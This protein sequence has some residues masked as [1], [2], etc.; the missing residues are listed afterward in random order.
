MFMTRMPKS[1]KKKSG[2]TQIPPGCYTATVTDVVWSP[3]YRQG[4]AVDV[5]YLISVDDDDPSVTES[6]W[7]RFLLKSSSERT[8][9]F[10]ELLDEIGA[11]NYSDFIGTKLSVEFERASDSRG[12]YHS[13]IVAHSLME[14]GGQDDIDCKESSSLALGQAW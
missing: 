1:S 8:K 3:G 11:E 6:Y 12:Y 13:N 10:D 7:E 14:G 2:S 5:T 9:R 4:D